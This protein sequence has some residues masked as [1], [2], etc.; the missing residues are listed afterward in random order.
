MVGSILSCAGGGALDLRF[1]GK[2]RR[3][4]VD[5]FGGLVDW[6]KKEGFLVRH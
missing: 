4:F 1:K 5:V 2:K 3:V 6:W